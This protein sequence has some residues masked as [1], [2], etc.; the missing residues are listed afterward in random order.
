MNWTSLNL[1]LIHCAH[2]AQFFFVSLFLTHPQFLIKAVARQLSNE[3]DVHL[4]RDL[5]VY[6]QIVLFKLN[7][8][9]V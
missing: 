4:A 7:V 2:R 5:N 6:V 8:V 3:K 9:R 1:W